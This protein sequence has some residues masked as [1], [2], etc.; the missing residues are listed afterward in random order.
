MPRPAPVAAESSAAEQEA[1]TVSFGSVAHTVG[2]GEA[3]TVTVSLSA[4]PERSVTV[5]LTTTD[6]DGATSADYAGVP[7]NVVFDSGD[8]AK[9]F[10][11][12]AT[13]DDVDDDGERVQVALGTLPEGVSAGATSETTVA[14]TDDN[15][16]AVVEPPPAP[17]NLSAR[18]NDDGSI[19]LTWDALAD[20]S[21]T[22][23]QILRRRPPL[24]E[25]TLL[26]YV[27][28]TGSTSTT[29]TDTN[30]TAGIRH[31]YR[32]KAINEAGPGRRSR[33]ARADP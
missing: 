3:V 28:N 6:Q 19:T 1:I 4:D 21:V 30:V 17:R 15:V 2:E 16:P 29:F 25:K 7:A 22:G 10:T 24:G 13:A 8:T 11:F 14:I 26:V 5:P 18:V 27:E 12:S 33:F 23:Y 20:A 32:V 9:D 31:T